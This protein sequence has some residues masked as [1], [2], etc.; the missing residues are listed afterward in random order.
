MSPL[1]KAKSKCKRCGEAVYVRSGPDGMRY[2]LQEAD[3]AVL[4]AAWAE[5][6]AKD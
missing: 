4:E 5:S 1:P 3:L 6:S 2:L